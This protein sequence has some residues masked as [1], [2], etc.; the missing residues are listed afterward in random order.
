MTC[1]Y[2]AQKT[3]RTWNYSSN[4]DTSKAFAKLLFSDMSNVTVITLLPSS[5][6]CSNISLVKFSFTRIVICWCHDE[7]INIF[8]TWKQHPNNRSLAPNRS[9][10][11]IIKQMWERK[12]ETRY[13][14]RSQY[15]ARPW[16][17]G[18]QAS[19]F[20]FTRWTTQDTERRHGL[21]K[22][23]KEHFISVTLLVTVSPIIK[24]VRDLFKP[25]PWAHMFPYRTI[26]CVWTKNSV[27]C[28]FSSDGRP[29]LAGD[30]LFLSRWI[31]PAACA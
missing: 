29:N 16:K 21:N 23:S 31:S 3:I 11:L 13:R 12:R 1:F 19:Y 9:F 27:R 4:K 25:F 28:P 26:V 10:V 24:V 15:F 30:H 7:S 14:I 5:K 20:V 8:C 17:R 6:K 2:S 18:Y 22:Y